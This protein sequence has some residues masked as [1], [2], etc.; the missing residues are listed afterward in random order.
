M[1]GIL[2]IYYYT[3]HW[4]RVMEQVQG[5]PVNNRDLNNAH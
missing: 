1:V 5:A 3:I 4:S 2:K